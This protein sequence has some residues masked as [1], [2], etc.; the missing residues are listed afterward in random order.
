[1]NRIL[2]FLIRVG[3]FSFLH[4]RE[5]QQGIILETPPCCR[6]WR[7]QSPRRPCQPKTQRPGKGV[8]T[9]AVSHSRTPLTRTLSRFPSEQPCRPW[10]SSGS[11]NGTNFRTFLPLPP[12]PHSAHPLWAS[13]PSHS[14]Q[15]PPTPSWPLP[16][17]I[18]PS[19][20]KPAPPILT[21]SSRSLP[22]A[23]CLQ[24]CRQSTDC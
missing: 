21:A 2:L 17:L 23:Q 6:H 16:L 3:P 18:G 1:M 12:P 9:E 13:Y 19:H 10:I 15:A 24:R 22:Q 4:P 7:K 5:R 20:S 14:L 8:D 11:W